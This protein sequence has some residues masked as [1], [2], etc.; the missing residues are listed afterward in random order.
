L[1][2]AQALG[3]VH[4]QAAS[5]QLNAGWVAFNLGDY[6]QAIAHYGS[7]YAASL[8]GRLL[9][10]LGLSYWKLYGQSPI[11]AH[12][13]RAQDLLARF[14]ASVTPAHFPDDPQIPRSRQA[15]EALVGDIRAEVVRLD[16]A[17]SRPS[18]G[19]Q[20]PSPSTGAIGP[21]PAALPP[22]HGP[23]SGPA[24]SP[25]WPPGRA[26]L[27]LYGAAASLAVAALITGVLALQAASDADALASQG[28]F[29]LGNDRADRSSTLAYT[30]D[31]LLGA[32]VVSAG[33]GLWLHL[34]HVRASYP[35]GS[36][37]ALLPHGSG[38]GLYVTF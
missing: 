11:R 27:L 18:L 6:E 29:A 34:R 26:P 10:N 37:V 9:F 2:R 20:Q 7:A 28:A 25:G 13:L 23:K 33:L 3:R 24:S 14:L 15:A 5:P 16:A 8:D 21:A 22:N 4:T 32:A 12:L 19:A 36:S 1:A 30:T 38:A 17:A 35:S 31:A